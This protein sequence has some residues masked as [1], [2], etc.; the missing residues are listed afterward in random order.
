MKQSS[1][2]RIAATIVSF[3]LLTTTAMYAQE[4]NSWTSHTSFNVVNDILVDENGSI[5]G[6][7]NGGVFVFEDGA[8]TQTL[9][10][11][12]GLAELSA[13]VIKADSEN[14][15]I[16]LGYESGRLDIIDSES[17]DITTLNDIQRANQ[18]SPRGVNDILISEDNLFV[19]TDFGI[20]V[21]DLNTLLVDNTFTK[22]GRFDR[23]ITVNDILIRDGILYAGTLQGI[24]F[25]N[26]RE[27][28][29]VLQS[30]WQN[31]S[32][33]NG[34]PGGLVRSIAF[35]DD[36]LYAS[37]SEAGN[38]M[39]NGVVWQQSNALGSE[40]VIEFEVSSDGNQL[41]GLT[42]NTI[43]TTTMSGVQNT[44][45]VPLGR[46][47]LSIALGT[48][49]T[50]FDFVI[51][52]TAQGFLEYNGQEATVRKADG[53]SLNF[54][55]GLTFR[56][57]TLY[58]GTTRSFVFNSPL[59][60]FKTYNIFDGE[61]WT[62]FNSLNNNALAAESF[63]NAFRTA[64]TDSTLYVGS[65]GTGVLR[66]DLATNEI[67]IF[68]RNNSALRGIPNSLNFIVTPG[69]ELDS[70]NGVWIT[71]FLSQIPMFYLPPGSDDWVPIPKA[72]AVQNADQYFNMLVDQNDQ[73]WVA[74]RTR[75]QVGAGLLVFDEGDLD[76]PTDNR[77]I[78]LNREFNNG[79]LPNLSVNAFAEDQNGEVW[80]ATSRGVARFLFAE[81]I[82]EP[83]AVQE[84]RAQWL[85][86]ADTTAASPF[87]LRD[88]DATALAVNGAN[89]KW[90]GTRNDGLWLV[91]EEGSRILTHFTTE[92]SPL[93]DNTINSI[94][95][96]QE[97]GTVYIGTA[98]GLVSFVDVP[99]A[100]V[101]ELNSLFVFPNPFSYDKH[102]GGINIE[103]LTQATSVNIMT[104]D[105]HMVRRIEAR[106]G[107]INWDGRN[108]NGQK[109]AT[110]VYFI[111]ALDNN[112][113]EKAVGKV[114]IVR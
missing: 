20:V 13:Q 106:G 114:L 70:E 81:L 67:E 48:G 23:G 86:N 110:G 100:P 82:L 72:R 113:E 78:K 60:R 42:S 92:N 45:S 18:F 79:N 21:Y 77:S 52:S 105:G 50:S 74:L 54:I 95:I 99:T 31:F 93:I 53:P 16:V 3:W 107:R 27:D 47:A 104:I 103:N 87:L 64:V 7:T 75:Q 22:L 76:D 111:V 24:A 33:S 88:I 56:N 43:F 108:F 25:G 19:A 12:D 37:I 46:P 61:G 34:L 10:T 26:F 36:N 51:G 15:L 109:L 35:F 112:T 41:F 80:I 65:W 39:Y 8:F 1:L 71:S 55:D 28:D 102:S 73:K 59:N 58:A 29:L 2:L 66:Q 11:I 84:R 44:T 62:T 9:T 68:N 98:S 57:E 91:N 90:I 30:N 89:Q 40:S 38:F 96:D 83:G 49:N 6:T 4:I 94:T 17:G 85:L 63:I 101:E 5:W 14:N 69:L 97:S 32:Q